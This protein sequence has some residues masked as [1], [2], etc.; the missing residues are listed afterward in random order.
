M[1]AERRFPHSVLIFVSLGIAAL[2]SAAAP[3]AVAKIYDGDTITLEDGTRVRL[4][5]IDA[6]ELRQ[7]CQDGKGATYQCGEKARAALAAAIGGRPVDC[8][9]RDRD[10]YGRLVAQCSAGGEDIGEALV[11]GGWAVA[12]T[13][14]TDRYAPIEAEA[15]RAGRGIWSGRFEAPANWRKDHR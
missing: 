1:A 5:G 4:W 12:Y 6:P 15:R 13:R 10:R 14:F 2:P 3:A 8:E 9:Y 11:R 7:A